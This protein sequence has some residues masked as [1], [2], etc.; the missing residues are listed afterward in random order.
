ML[1]S[2]L[3]LLKTCLCLCFQKYFFKKLLIFYIFRS[4]WYINIKN[5][6]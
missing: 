2:V 5:N 6:F 4:F 3:Y 1:E